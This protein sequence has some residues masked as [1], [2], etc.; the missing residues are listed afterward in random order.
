MSKVNIHQI[1][2][3]TK[4]C[5]K[6]VNCC[7]CNA[8]CPVISSSGLEAIIYSELL[9]FRSLFAKSCSMIEACMA[10]CTYFPIFCNN[11]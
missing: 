11:L 5:V 8:L 1:Y 4:D 3:I 6:F 2:T 9:L 7:G 10:I